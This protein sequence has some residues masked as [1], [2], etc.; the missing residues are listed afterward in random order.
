[1]TVAHDSAARGPSVLALPP[2][3]PLL[4]G[5]HNR[6]LQ[7]RPGGALGS[8]SSA[9]LVPAGSGSGGAGGGGVS[10]NQGLQRGGGGGVGMSGPLASGL[11]AALASTMSGNLED[12]LEDGDDGSLV[13]FVS[14]FVH[15]PSAAWTVGML[16]WRL[17]GLVLCMRSTICCIQSVL[18]VY[19]CNPYF[20]VTA[21]RSC[22]PQSCKR[23]ADWITDA[24]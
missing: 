4:H 18:L 14:K 9:G 6:L 8:S 10:S 23:R 1:M 7:L 5:S 15:A 13:V 3:L 20:N 24:G 2:S 12:G 21:H 19:C 11:G 22:L 17:L 16:V